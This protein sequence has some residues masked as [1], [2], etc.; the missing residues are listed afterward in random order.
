M[1]KAEAAA[2]AFFYCP[3]LRTGLKS[4]IGCNYTSARI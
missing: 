3:Q 2:S 1:S 4:G